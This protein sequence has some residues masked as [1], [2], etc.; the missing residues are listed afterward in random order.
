[1]K[2][3]DRMGRDNAEGGVEEEF[4][5]MYYVSVKM[6]GKLYTQGFMQ[7]ERG[8]VYGRDFCNPICKSGW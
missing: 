2:K 7:V 4:H 1:M 8:A 5:G 3:A 6:G